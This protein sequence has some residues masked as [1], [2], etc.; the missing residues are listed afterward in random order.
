MGVS[1]ATDS[2]GK[3]VRRSHESLELAA[4]LH[5]SV[6][7]QRPDCFHGKNAP[8]NAAD[9]FKS[10]GRPDQAR[11]PAKAEAPVPVTGGMHGSE[12]IRTSLSAGRTVSRVLCP[13]LPDASQV[14]HLP[15]L[16]QTSRQGI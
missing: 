10:P 6:R 14:V 3:A 7:R 13:R 4:S 9:D 16:T 1:G 8:A 2:L 5:T 15:P 11:H 12:R